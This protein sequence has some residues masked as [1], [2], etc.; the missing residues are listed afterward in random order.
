M[1]RLAFLGCTLLGVACAGPQTDSP[2]TQL[3]FTV[4]APGL[5]PDSSLCVAGS[6]EAWGPWKPC[7]LA[8][9]YMGDD[10]W[11]GTAPLSPQS[12]EYKFTLGAWAHEALDA[13]GQKRPNAALNVA[14]PVHVHDTVLA[15]S[16]ANTARRVVGQVT[17]QFESL[18]VQRAEGLLPREVWVWTPPQTAPPTPIGRVLVMHDGQNVVDPATSNFGVDWGADEVLDSLVRAGVLPRTLLIAAACTAERSAEY[19]PGRRGARYVDWLMKELVPDVRSQRN[20]PEDAPTTVAGAS[21]GGLISFIAAE[22]HP[23]LV[24]AAMCMSPAFGYAGFSYADSLQAR[25]WGGHDVPLWIDNGTVGLEEQLQ[26]GVDAMERLAQRLD[27]DH[28][29]NVYEGAKHFESDWG[30]RMPEAL[31]W[32][33]SAWT[34][35]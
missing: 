30:S 18:G 21:M 27:L 29:V 28:V 22:R 15:W 26:P 4:V 1:R 11:E 24:G 7:G 2:N 23:D 13:S 6:A 12:L 17:G 3:A 32:I 31:K 16:D 14:G 35:E 20:V 8:L 34:R 9:T 25:D 33:E 5:S 19:G 10:R